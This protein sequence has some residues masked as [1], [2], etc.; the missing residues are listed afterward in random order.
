[1]LQVQYTVLKLIGFLQMLQCFQ[2]FGLSP[3]DIR[4]L[5]L[6]RMI[7]DEVEIEKLKGEGQHIDVLKTF[8][9]RERL[10]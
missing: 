6:S 8:C 5:V 7:G 1:M 9:Y 3:S 4:H 10:K 2:A